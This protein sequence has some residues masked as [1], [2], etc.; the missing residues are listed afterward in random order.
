MKNVKD[1][2]K[3]ISDIYGYSFATDFMS[4]Y[5]KNELEKPLTNLAKGQ[6]MMFHFTENKK[7]SQNAMKIYRVLQKRPEDVWSFNFT[8]RKDDKEKYDLI[9]QI[10][11]KQWDFFRHGV[12]DK[13]YSYEDLW[14]IS[15]SDLKNSYIHYLSE[16]K[17]LDD[18]DERNRCYE[19]APKMELYNI[20]WNLLKG[21]ELRELL[22]RMEDAYIK[23]RA[24]IDAGGWKEGRKMEENE[25]YDQ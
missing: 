2:G 17:K 23:M 21:D 18:I 6:S 16:Y 20:E 5:K 1:I 8:K 22:S 19:L 10:V 24:I 4:R 25:F 12:I 15:N 11:E 7:Y 14:V 3:T 13:L 9:G